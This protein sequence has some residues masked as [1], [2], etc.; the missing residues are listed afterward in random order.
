MP[1]VAPRPSSF[2]LVF[3]MSLMQLWE[4]SIDSCH[5]ISSN[6]GRQ[7][8]EDRLSDEDDDDDD[9][10]LAVTDAGTGSGQRA[11]AMNAHEDPGMASVMADMEDDSDADSDDAQTQELK[12]MVSC[13]C[14]FSF[15]CV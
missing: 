1:R 15:S 12:D 13:H 9:S 4:E 8:K 11:S 3:V 6:F 5:Y 14:S 2:I 10:V 7:P